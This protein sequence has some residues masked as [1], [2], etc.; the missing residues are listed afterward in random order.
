M[1]NFGLAR[2]PGKPRTATSRRQ[3]RGGAAPRRQQ[4]WQLL[5]LLRT[6]PSR[7]QSRGEVRQIVKNPVNRKGR[8]GNAEKIQAQHAAGCRWDP[9]QALAKTS[10]TEPNVGQ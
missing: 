10:R 2:Q 4:F 1:D 6:V 9:R 8:S 5:R 7:P 3:A